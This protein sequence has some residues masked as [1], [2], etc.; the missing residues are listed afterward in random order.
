MKNEITNREGQ[1]LF[2][3]EVRNNKLYLNDV[4]GKQL[5][6]IEHDGKHLQLKDEKD[7]IL[8]EIENEIET[9]TV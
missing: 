2:T 7:N 9:P 4:T 5:C 1:I 8:M 6:C 3:A